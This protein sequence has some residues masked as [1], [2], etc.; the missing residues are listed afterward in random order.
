MVP[1]MGE[2]FRGGHY[3]EPNVLVH[4]RF[5]ERVDANGNRHLFFEEVQSDW[6]QKGRT[7]GYARIGLNAEETARLQVLEAKR[8]ASDRLTW[9]EMINAELTPE[10]LDAGAGLTQAESGE[11]RGLLN[12]SSSKFAT[13]VPD[14][15]FK[16]TWPDL[17]LKRM[18]H[19]A[20]ENGF[21]RI[22]WTTGAQQAKRYD[23]SKHIEAVYATQHRPFMTYRADE[24]SRSAARGAGS[25]PVSYDLQIML[26]GRRDRRVIVVAEND[27]P[28]Y[29]GKDLAD[30]II[31]QGGG[32]FRGL[33]LKV[34]GE[35]MKSFYDRRLVN[36]ANKIG[37][38]YGAKVGKSQ[39]DFLD[40]R[41]DAGGF[42]AHSMVITPE[43]KA[44]VL[45]EGL[46]LFKD[47]G[48]VDKPLYERAL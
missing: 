45:K 47:G 1:R 7:Q 48:F 22:A 27:L 17:A 35:G 18:I 25:T 41:G 14:A 39:F 23:L 26:H 8:G 19:Y 28:A 34:G 11:Y 30:K 38:K 31:E 6:H 40:V 13:G 33:D 4:V 20:A 46:P 5:N 42:T 21:D 3:K 44:K 15:P 16:K 43:L 37:K 12:R 32:Q 2:E 29:V 24:I 10:Q 36:S 9:D